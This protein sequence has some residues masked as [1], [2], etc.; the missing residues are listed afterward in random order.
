MNIHLYTSESADQAIR[1]IRCIN[2]A[3]H[4]Q[5]NFIIEPIDAA[6]INYKSNIE[7]DDLLILMV[8]NHNELDILIDIKEIFTSNR[9]IIVLNENN[10][11][12]INKAYL[13]NPRFV[14]F[15]EG[16]YHRLI[17]IINKISSQYAKFPSPYRSCR[18][19]CQHQGGSL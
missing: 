12:I 3:R 7:I 17:E 9:V 1:L 4:Y 18:H 11:E 6:N 15:F 5:D 14:E 2:N 13:L 19:A 16:S 8:S 10:D